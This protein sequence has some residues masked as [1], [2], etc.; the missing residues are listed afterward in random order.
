MRFAIPLWAELAAVGL[1]GLQGALFAAGFRRIDLLGVMVIGIGVSLGGS[2]LRDV[3]LDELPAVV[4]SNWYLPVA[5]ASAIVGMALRPLLRR[6]DWVVTG[7]DA[8][9]I[10]TFGA[11]GASKA[12]S[13]GV[14]EVGAVFIGVIAAV[15]GSVVRDLLMGLPVAFLQ[16]GSL[17]AVAAGAGATTFVVLAR[18][19]TPVPAAGIACIAVATVLRLGA[20]RFGWRFPEQRALSRPRWR[21]PAASALSR[22][23]ISTVSRR[24]TGMEQ[25]HDSTI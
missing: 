7:L 9:V 23:L 25:R 21:L 12:M 16:V 10:G 5:A 18:A 3:L 13:L 17:F 4:G 1:G 14:S 22:K 2:L 20:V 6:A 8:V 24:A 11:I 15:G 19:G